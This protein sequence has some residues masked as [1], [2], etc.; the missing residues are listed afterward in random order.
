MENTYKAQNLN[1]ISHYYK[2]VYCTKSIIKVSKSD[3][4][5]MKWPVIKIGKDLVKYKGCTRQDATKILQQIMGGWTTQGFFKDISEGLCVIKDM[6]VWLGRTKEY[7]KD[8]QWETVFRS[9]IDLLLSLLSYT[10]SQNWISMCALA[11]KLYNYIC[12]I[13]NQSVYVAQGLEDIALSLVSTLLPNSIIS[14]I[15]RMQMFTSAK[16]FDDA[17]TMQQIFDCFAELLTA[18]YMAAECV[19]PNPLREFCQSLG[20]LS[21]KYKFSRDAKAIIKVFENNPKACIDPE[22]TERVTELYNRMTQSATLIEYGRKSAYIKV[23]IDKVTQLQKNIMSH[24][25]LSRPEPTAFILEGPPGCGKSTLL[26]KLLE[27]MDEPAYSHI[28]KPMEDAKDYYD[29]YQNEKL[30]YMD[31]VGQMSPAQWRT[32]IN[33]V[34]CAKMPL[35]CADA[36]LKNTKYFGSEI[37]LCTTNSFME[38]NG[39]IRSDGIADI[40]ALKRRGHV[41]DMTQMKFNGKYTGNISF[42]IYNMQEK[43]FVEDFPVTLK[44]YLNI[45]K[46]SIP[47]RLENPTEDEILG[48]MFAI[49]TNMYNMKQKHALDNRIPIDRVKIIREMYTQS[50]ITSLL[51]LDYTQSLCERGVIW[52]E[53]LSD[54]VTTSIKTVTSLSLDTLKDGILL[55][56]IPSFLLYMY[57]TKGSFKDSSNVYKPQTMENLT[58]N[59]KHILAERKEESPHSLSVSISKQVL[60]VVVT[61][62]NGKT[63][64]GLCL[65][66]G[67]KLLVPAHNCNNSVSGFVSVMNGDGIGCIIDN[68]AYTREYYN[69]QE[70]IAIL[71]MPANI[72]SYFKN[73]S[74]IFEPVEKITKF[75]MCA[76]NQ[77]ATVKRTVKILTDA[78]ILY[79]DTQQQFENVIEIDKDIFY[80]FQIAGMC[81]AIISNEFGK[82]IGMHVTGNETSN[83]GASLIW[84]TA[85]RADIFNILNNDTGFFSKYEMTKPIGTSGFKINKKEF[86][87]TNNKSNLIPSPLYA[88]YETTRKPAVLDVDG[89]HT[90]K[91]F[92]KKS[93]IKTK[94]V[95]PK[96]LDFATEA[97]KVYIKPFSPITEE[98]VVQ[99]NDF[100]APFN[101]ESSNG[102]GCT[103]AKTD[104]IDKEKSCLTDKCRGEIK[105]LYDEITTGVYNDEHWLWKEALKDEIR[106]DEKSLKPRT[107]R[108]ARVHTQILMKQLFGQ[109]V[110]DIMENRAFNEIMI[111]VNPYSEWDSIYQR[112]QR[113][114]G[115]WAGDIGSYDGNMLP[116]VQNLLHD[117]LLE[118]FVGTC[119]EKAMVSFLLRDM[120]NTGVVVNDDIWRTTHSMP[121]GSYLTAIG[122]SLINRIYTLMWYYEN[123][124]EPSY[125]DFQSEVIDYVYGDDKLNGLKTSKYRNNLNA[126]TMEKFFLSIGMSFTTANKN[127]IT[128]PFESL[129][130]ISFLKRSFLYHPILKKI[131]CPL[132]LRT[133]QSGLSWYDSTKDCAIV[134]NDKIA[135]FQREIYLHPFFIRKSMLEI[136]KTQCLSR[137]VEFIPLSDEYLFHIYTFDTESLKSRSWG[138][139]KYV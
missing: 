78:P 22:M 137:D 70:D 63:T 58:T 4:Q 7:I 23:L 55:M 75:T 40:H 113:A 100:L 97:I 2:F 112:L 9:T 41:F 34:S 64:H 82:A 115:V 103:I 80:D 107:F 28:V 89:P 129:S 117:V 138:G 16:L 119:E 67:H 102:Y 44:K 56:C 59:V 71:A 43:S 13:N 45:R 105:A 87:H 46:I 30:F 39:L 68:V 49:V 60:P 73:M 116:Q 93:F 42:K 12:M 125:L 104:Y 35:A 36:K 47:T 48:W 126:L 99:G 81:G 6:L 33:I 92:A 50:Y 15:K 135:S 76:L 128:E 114:N 61:D 14:V 127:K 31:D 98:V 74:S 95:N 18:L 122:N 52:M 136:L 85:T 69:S 21:G 133:L 90:V 79:K 110:S 54:M 62:N 96:A 109:F 131:M 19:M 32:L 130:D 77:C 88:V 124:E 108:V 118:K 10:S 66:S 27:V 20:S 83:V 134:I 25:D 29:T 57:F 38:L 3:F 86:S 5:N 17:S 139:T 8:V 24:K 120:M 65:L 111:G 11:Y 123:V 101:M 91:T 121:S 84:S 94:N 37:V 51:G 132:E 26:T 1:I 106:N 53:L 72:P